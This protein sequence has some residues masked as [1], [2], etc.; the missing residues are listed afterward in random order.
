M[1]T[2]IEFF[3]GSS[4][5]SAYFKSKGWRVLTVDYNPKFGA[6][7]CINIYDYLD[8]NFYKEKLGVDKIDFIWASPDC[9]TYSLAAGSKHRFKGG[10]PKSEYANYCDVMNERFVNWLKSLHIPFIIENPLGHFQNMS[11]VNGLYRYDVDYMSYGGTYLK[12]TCFFSNMVTLIF[13][14]PKFRVNKVFVSLKY[15]SSYLARCYIP[16]K[17]IAAIYDNVVVFIKGRFSTISFTQ[18]DLFSLEY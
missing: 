8:I 14:E 4:R 17:L 3:S 16:D 7:L 6:D 2:M 18:L 10:C 5:I 11:F 15:C 13:L 12:P 9:A 1:Y